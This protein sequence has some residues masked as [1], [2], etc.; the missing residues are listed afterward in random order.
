MQVAA[1]A[2]AMK[3]VQPPPVPSHPTQNSNLTSF[4]SDIE[5]NPNI[6]MSTQSSEL[7]RAANATDYTATDSSQMSA[8]KQENRVLKARLLLHED[9]ILSN[10]QNS[11]DFSAVSAV[12]R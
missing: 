3:G 8:L 7:E 11:V 12:Y 5:M 6:L 2:N 4:G 10:Q 1:K 9:Q